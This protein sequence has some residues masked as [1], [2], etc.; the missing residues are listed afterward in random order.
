MSVSLYYTARRRQPI[1]L[2]EKNSCDE[3][4][5]SYDKQYPFGEMYEGF[6]IYDLKAL[7]GT[8]EED[9]ILDGATKLPPDVDD[10]SFFDILGY[11][12]ECLEEIAGV[13]TDAKWTVHLDDMDFKWSEEKHGFVPDV[14]M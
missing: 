5:A 4:A 1:S 6:C 7:A 13:L 12:L 2:Q 8:E 14:E 11:W 3:I 9:V 10:E